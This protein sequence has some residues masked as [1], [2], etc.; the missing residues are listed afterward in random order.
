VVALVV[1][2]V[3]AASAKITGAGGLQKNGKAAKKAPSS[4]EEKRSNALVG[5]AANSALS[6]AVA[7]RGHSCG[8]GAK[9]RCM[10]ARL[11]ACRAAARHPCSR[12]NNYQ[13]CLFQF[14]HRGW[15]ILSISQHQRAATLRYAWMVAPRLALL[16][17]YSLRDVI[18]ALC[19]SDMRRRTSERCILRSRGQSGHVPALCRRT[20]FARSISSAACCAPSFVPGS[21]GCGR[22]SRA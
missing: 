8:G 7:R 4:K 20:A 3:G 6:G 11:Q 12:D 22:C 5:I 9:K 14:F 15:F 19:S 18:K 16:L 2:Y 21:G 10:A 13:R 17:A 1:Q